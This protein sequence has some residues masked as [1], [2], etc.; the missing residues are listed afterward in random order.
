MS[1][2]EEWLLINLDPTMARRQGFPATLPVPKK[3]FESIADKG[4]HA[5]SARAWC[6]DFLGNSEIGK[7]GA[8]RK[9]NREMVVAME[10]FIDTG[11]LWE[12][13]QKAFSENDYE[14]AISTLKKIVVQA[15]SD[16]AAK[17]N[18]ASA[19]ANKN[20]MENALKYFKA[21]AKTFKGDA[22]FHIALGHV[23]IRKQD[24][25]LAIEE[26]V[27]ALEAKP[28]HQGA[29][30][31]LTQLG[32]LVKIFE[33]PRDAA[34]MLYV[35]ADSVVSYLTSQWDEPLASGE[36][37]PASF[38][39]EQIAYHEREQRFEVVLAAADRALKAAGEAGCEPAEL[40]R[41]AAL[42]SLNR[43]GEALDAAKDYVERS[44][45]SAPALIE[46]ARVLGQQGNSADAEVTI[47][48][49]LAKDPGDL[50]AIMLKFWPEDPNDVQK[51]GDMLPNLEKFVGEHKDVPGAIRS[52]ARAFLT[53][54]RLE[55]ALD[56]FKQAV[57]LRPADD[58]LR[59]EWWGELAKQQKYDDVIADANKL[60]DMKA[61]DWRLRWNEAEAYSG[62]G[63]T[64]EARACFSAIN[65]D[66]SLHVDIRKRAKRA[67]NNVDEKI[68]E[69]GL[70]G[71]PAPAP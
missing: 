59:S 2:G 7:N 44:G 40:A 57:D 46:L 29:L 41:I 58:D 23:Y 49:A 33:N 5:K 63:K 27:S 11:P 53:L 24:K 65:F 1:E 34:S 18:L 9:K 15:E 4:L 8:W 12:K 14:K 26:F 54:N 56:L 64:L 16:D 39:L 28:D 51:I 67:V 22:E 52:L 71:G 68:R 45:E 25:D 61:R 70:G 19:Y 50:T 13:A 35:R 38:F 55:E 42:R 3:E 6:S 21:I 30:D 62:L 66:E 48:K 37:R 43:L 32:V 17:L 36:A 60:G 47:D 69:S 10:A 31:S 20:D